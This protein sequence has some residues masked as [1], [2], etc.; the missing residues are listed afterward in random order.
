MWWFGFELFVMDED[1]RIH[2]LLESCSLLLN[3]LVFIF[4][5]IFDDFDLKNDERGMK[6]RL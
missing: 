1:F 5:L 6:R 4:F 3:V 2:V